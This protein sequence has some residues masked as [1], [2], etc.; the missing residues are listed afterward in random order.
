MKVAMVI[1]NSLRSLG[2]GELVCISTCLALQNLGY[3]VKL[4]TDRFEPEEIE[5]AFGMGEV[6]RKCE[7][8]RSP[9]L[10]RKLARISS[11]PGVFFAWR[12]R[13][14]LAKQRADIVFV[15]RDPKRPDILPKRPLF[16]FMYEF[17]QLKDFW[18]HYRYP[19][20]FLYRALYAKDRPTTTFLA[21]SSSLMVQL[22]REGYATTELVY[23]SYGRGFHP[24]PK[25]NHV[26]QV[27]FLA[28]QKRIEDFMEIARRIPECKFYLV[29]RDT[30]RVN[31]IYGGYAQSVLGGKPDNVEYVEARIRQSPEFLEESKI[32]LHTGRE[33]GM[34]I[35]V[36]EA[37]S[38]GC[39][40]V[41]PREGGA[42]EVLRV[43]RVGFHYDNLEDAV[44]FIRSQIGEHREEPS[45][46]LAGPDPLEIEDRAR[47]FG[48]DAFQNRIKDMIA[49][50]VPSQQ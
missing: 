45:T 11:L 46:N 7:R 24:R 43:A 23:P 6:L 29:G 49:R 26:V 8:I 4:V 13:R 10:G 44:K 14:F 1:Q 28:P 35:A 19:M 3:H 2:G 37:L 30:K 31:R 40:P 27:T 15:T 32:Y 21:V 50:S 9:Q 47:I 16:R 20:R 17:D 42:G 34:T 12:S 33:P 41:A 5:A 36:M 18:E 39:L 48:P 38:A 22:K 25:K